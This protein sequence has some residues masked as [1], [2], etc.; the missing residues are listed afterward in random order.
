MRRL[1]GIATIAGVAL[2]ALAPGAPAQVAVDPDMVCPDMFVP[3]LAQIA[4]PGTDKNGNF[5]VCVKEED[6]HL[7]WRDDLLKP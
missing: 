3:F 6:S 4:P 5:I 7:I 2:A 1:G